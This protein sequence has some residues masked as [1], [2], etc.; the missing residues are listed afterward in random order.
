M[1]YTTLPI[2]VF[3]LL[4]A[5]GVFATGIR[6]DAQARHLVTRG[7]EIVV[8]YES[9]R[10]TRRFGAQVLRYLRLP[11]EARA[12]SKTPD[13]VSVV[14]SATGTVPSS[15][16]VVEIDD[17][18][19]QRVCDEIRRKNAGIPLTC[20]ANHI[21][22]I[23]AQ[24]NDP[25][26]SSLYGMSKIAAPEAWEISTGS[27]AVTVAVVDTGVNYNHPDLT[28]NI[29]RNLGEIPSNG[30][31]DDGNGYIDDY[32]GYDFSSGDGDPADGHR[33]GSHCAGTIG[34]RGNNE[35]GVVGVNW[36]VGILPVRVLN[37]QGSGD[38]ADVAAGIRYAVDRGASIVS[39]SL[40][41]DSFSQTMEDAIEY[42]R[43]AGVLIV[44]AAGNGSSNNDDPSEFPTYPASSPAD[45]V[46]SVAATDSSDSLSYYSNYGATSVDV[47]APGDSI[48]STTLGTGYEEL[49]GTSMATPHVAG[50]AA[51]IKS[52]NLSYGYAD[53]KTIIMSTVDPRSNLYGK[54][55][56][57]GRVNAQSALVFATTGI[58]P[59]PPSDPGRGSSSES[60]RNTLT[61]QSQRYGRKILLYGRIYDSAD[62]PVAKSYVHLRCQNAPRRRRLSDRDG[63]YG[64]R[65]N[66]PRQ[67]GLCFVSDERG[68][69]SRVIRLR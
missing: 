18:D 4:V 43:N 41:G 20:E 56:S 40:G 64:F 36:E 68:T 10:G 26:F 19:V 21:R 29:V 47:A 69:R 31:D 8:T 33:H 3:A 5:S 38:D 32:Y 52:T 53:L 35:L 65:I 66:P 54:M 58:N 57:G 61:L 44:A 51:L 1:R 46:L 63:F 45:N 49:S 48:L 67:R 60:E 42:A 27:S 7:R 16:G 12:H 15:A 11:S 37:N 30:I 2:K 50:L 55:V 23:L 22:T 25:E 6:A 34:A 39:M 17:Q 13:G 9:T 24:P 62:S 28:D 59:A 14:V